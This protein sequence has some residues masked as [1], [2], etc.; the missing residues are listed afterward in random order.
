MIG[1][2][3]IRLVEAIVSYFVN[4]ATLALYTEY[5]DPDNL[6]I[7]ATV[8]KAVQKRPFLGVHVKDTV[9][10]AAAHTGW[11]RSRVQICS[12]SSDRLV[13]LRIMDYVERLSFGYDDPAEINR[14]KLSFSNDCIRNPSTN[15]IRRMGV[16]FNEYYN[17]FESSIMIEVIWID[18]PCDENECPT[19][20]DFTPDLGDID[21]SESNC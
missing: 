19:L 13:C 6:S 5:S 1:E 3:E 12:Y 9:P 10:F 2:G 11:R 15:Y 14:K 18:L 4:D 21:C 7:S 8:P 16:E 17:C 20:P